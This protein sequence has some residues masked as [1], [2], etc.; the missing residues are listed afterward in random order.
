[1]PIT[2]F[3]LLIKIKIPAITNGEDMKS[4]PINRILQTFQPENSFYK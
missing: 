3:N 4:A 1:M 2:F